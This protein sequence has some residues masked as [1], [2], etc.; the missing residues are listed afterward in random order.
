MQKPIIRKSNKIHN[1]I[2]MFQIQSTPG[3]K[4]AADTDGF[5]NV[6]AWEY[7]GY[8]KS[9]RYTC[10][11]DT[12]GRKAGNVMPIEFDLALIAVITGNQVVYG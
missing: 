9:A 6:E 7:L 8:L 11:G 10:L 1:F 4:T 2:R 3:T 5:L 12:V